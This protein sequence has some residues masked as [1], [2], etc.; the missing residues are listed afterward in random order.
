MSAPDGSNAVQLT[1][2]K[3]L[4][5]FAR[6]TPD[7]ETLAFHSDPE[8]HPDVLTVRASRGTPFAWQTAWQSPATNR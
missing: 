5:G 1:T 7:G 6:W 4:P 8:G 3:S 2:L